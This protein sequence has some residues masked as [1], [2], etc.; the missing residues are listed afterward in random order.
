MARKTS[1]YGSQEFAGVKLEE[2]YASWDIEEA[3]KKIESWKI[4][5]DKN[6]QNHVYLDKYI[7]NN[8]NKCFKARN[9]TF[10]DIIC[11]NYNSVYA[12]IYSITYN[13]LYVMELSACD[14]AGYMGYFGSSTLEWDVMPM[15][16]GNIEK[17]IAYYF[18]RIDMHEDVIKSYKTTKQEYE[19]R[20]MIFN[21]V[22][23]GELKDSEVFI[24]E[25]EQDEINGIKPSY[26]G[27]TD[28]Q[29]NELKSL[30]I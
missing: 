27:L 15:N 24:D 10:G 20:N 18:A 7:N 28:K 21:A 2:A 8:R 22:I 3:L 13:V 12:L 17:Y 30:P 14:N 26:Y 11:L 6:K 29:Y 4:D 19:Y 9:C 16:E 25:F 1:L 5:N 23:S